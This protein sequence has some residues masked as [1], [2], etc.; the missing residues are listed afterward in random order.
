GDEEGERGE[1]AG[2]AGPGASPERVTWVLRAPDERGATWVRR[3]R[4]GNLHTL[5][6]AGQWPEECARAPATAML[7]GISFP[8]FPDPT[9]HALAIAL[10][11]ARPDRPG[12]PRRG[13]LRLGATPGSARC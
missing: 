7:R 4:P 6:A 12:H 2:A 3:Q 1:G 10:V 11:A 13:R 8:P 5:P 9:P